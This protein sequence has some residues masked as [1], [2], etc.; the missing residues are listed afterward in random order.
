MVINLL[1]FTCEGTVSHG[2]RTRTF[3]FRAP[4]PRS[5]ADLQERLLMCRSSAARSRRSLASAAQEARDKETK[6][7]QMTF[8]E[9]P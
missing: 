7:G 9:D 2:V 8:P 3:K 5:A 1:R 4:I 6:R